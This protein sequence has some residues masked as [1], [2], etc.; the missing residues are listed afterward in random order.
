MDRILNKVT[1]HAV[2]D[3]SIT[4]ALRFA[5]ANGFAGVQLAVEMPHLSFE[6][7]T[8]AQC[9]EIA[10]AR[11]E[12]GLWVSLHAP[13][14]MCCLF[15][16]SPSLTD[17]IFA[18]FAALIDFAERIG[19]GLVNVHLGSP[20]RFRTADTPARTLPDVDVELYY[21]ALDANLSRLAGLAHRRV[22][23]CV[24]AFDLQPRTIEML[25]RHLDAGH[26]HLCWDLAKTYDADRNII[27]P[28]EQF[29]WR[30]LDRIRQVHLHDRRGSHSHAVINTGWVNFTHFL[31]RLVETDIAEYCIEVRPR[32]KALTSLSSL[33][34]MVSASL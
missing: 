27:A 26:M 14:T 33:K 11:A 25:Q 20:A 3:D 23:L 2:Y 8:D 29:C 6:R 30:N 15:E 28:L 7:L 13:D 34:A 9:D 4:D 5:A 12:H 19:A 1:Y 18:Y 32:D 24:E 21:Q 31:P 10:T 17:G 16:H 22:V